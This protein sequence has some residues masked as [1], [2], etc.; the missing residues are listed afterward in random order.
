MGKVKE[1]FMRLLEENPE[2]FDD[3]L[4]DSYYEERDK[5]EQMYYQSE[6]YLKTLENENNSIDIDSVE[7]P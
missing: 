5:W 3:H 6:E 7:L 4:D 2:E 1:L